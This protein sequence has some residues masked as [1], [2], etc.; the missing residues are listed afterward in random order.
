M[1]IK[2]ICHLFKKKKNRTRKKPY[3]ALFFSNYLHPLCVSALAQNNLM[4]NSSVLCL[5]WPDNSFLE[6]D[7]FIYFVLCHRSWPSQESIA[8]LTAVNVTCTLCFLFTNSI[9]GFKVLRVKSHPKH[10]ATAVI[11][12]CAPSSFQ[13]IDNDGPFSLDPCSAC[14][15]PSTYITRLCLPLLCL[16]PCSGG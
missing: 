14:L 12:P 8:E 15:A 16:R 4:D 7:L 10:K 1:I 13:C 9:T 6:T 11:L 5:Q 3:S 2:S